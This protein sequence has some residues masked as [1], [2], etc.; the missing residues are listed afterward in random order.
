[1]NGSVWSSAS[2]PC[3]TRLTVATT[4][5]TMTVAAC[6]SGDACRHPTIHAHLLPCRDFPGSRAAAK[7]MKEWL[8]AEVLPELKVGPAAGWVIMS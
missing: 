8:E 7:G 6:A 2:N 3:A 4:A 5:A 1:M